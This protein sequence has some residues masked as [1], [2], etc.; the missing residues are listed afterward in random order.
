MVLTAALQK[1]LNQLQKLCPPDGYEAIDWTEFNGDPD[2][3]LSYLNE[4]A[5]LDLVKIKYDDENVV[6]VAVTPTGRVL[7]DKIKITTEVNKRITK[8]NNINS[9]LGFDMKTGIYFGLFIF[10]LA[11]LGGFLGALLGG[12]L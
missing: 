4:L 2:A 3:V 5:D 1:L 6:C 12:W 10:G 9:R 7:Q 8:A 11:F